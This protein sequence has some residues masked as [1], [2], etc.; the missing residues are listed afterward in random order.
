VYFN[1]TC[2]GG[3]T[4]IYYFASNLS[5]DNFVPAGN[6][7]DTQTKCNFPHFY[8]P[9]AKALIDQFHQ[10]TDTGKQLAIMAQ[11]EALMVKDFPIVPVMVQ[12]TAFLYSTKYFTGFPT[13]GNDYAK[14]P[15]WAFPDIGVVLTRVKPVM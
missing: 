4:P 3:Q 10:Q 8:D 12:P 15:Y 13:A 5:K 11:L 1:Y 14:G 2:A 6:F 9:A 7:L